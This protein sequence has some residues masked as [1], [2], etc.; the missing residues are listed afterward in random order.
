MFL[1]LDIKIQEMKHKLVLLYQLLFPVCLMHCLTK[2][3]YFLI[4]HLQQFSHSSLSF[5]EISRTAIGGLS[6]KYTYSP[7][8]TLK[9]IDKELD[10]NRKDTIC[11]GVW[12]GIMKTYIFSKSF[13]L[14]CEYFELLGEDFNKEMLERNTR[15]LQE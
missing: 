7:L 1:F 2:I 11:L 12:N 8:P 13:S 9:A 14:E 15:H 6:I 3:G 4:R 10:S 5:E